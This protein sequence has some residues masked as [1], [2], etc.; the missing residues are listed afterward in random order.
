M[1][2]TIAGGGAAINALATAVGASV[3]V[4]NV[5]VSTPLEDAEG[6]VSRLVRP[7]TGN[8][9]EEP[10][11]SQDG[12]R[13]AIRA[14]A[15]TAED[16]VAGGADCLIGGDMGIGNT[17]PTVALI[18]AFTGVAPADITGPGAGVPVAG[19]AHKT[20]L[21]NRAINRLEAT[22]DPL[23]IL[24]EVGGLEIAAL[25][26]F[27]MRASA[28]RVPFIV[29]GVIACAALVVADALSPGTAA[30]AIAG[31]RSAEPAATA[32]LAHV[33]LEPLLD[34]NLRLGEGTGATLAFPLVA[35]AARAL[36]FMAD[37]PEA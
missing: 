26:G 28:L 15:Q 1:V 14:G 24:A 31:H 7:G 9:A 8:I 22:S 3:L 10:A 30:A 36:T 6:I 16:L 29:D 23:A 11:M 17:T 13:Q 5:G 12:A 37:L 4:V 33:G 21:V 20:A 34:L 19:L 18:S 2:G 35:A 25:A 27:Y 32:A